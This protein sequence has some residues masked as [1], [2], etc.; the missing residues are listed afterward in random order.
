MAGRQSGGQGS[1]N[2]SVLSPPA[3]VAARAIERALQIA[4]LT[5]AFGLDLRWSRARHSLCGTAAEAPDRQP[6]NMEARRAF[7]ARVADFQRDVY[8][9]TEASAAPGELSLTPVLPAEALRVLAV[10]VA[11]YHRAEDAARDYAVFASQPPLEQP[12]ALG[13]FPAGDAAYIWRET[14]AY[15]GYGTHVILL[16]RGRAL[17]RLT[18]E[19]Y[20][21]DASAPA[22]L[23]VAHLAA[24][25]LAEA[26]D[27]ALQE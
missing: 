21:T 14:A 26:L 3:P 27:R 12:L 25:R 1:G 9:R 19:P 22:L 17:A 2:G 16:R 23:P 8:M 10:D 11:I 24:I 13:P 5:P 20:Y 4:F 6:R 18:A 15:A 7:C